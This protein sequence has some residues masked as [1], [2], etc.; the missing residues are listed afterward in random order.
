MRSLTTRLLLNSGDTYLLYSSLASVIEHAKE[1]HY[2][3]LCDTQGAT[4]TSAPNRHP[5]RRPVV[6][7]HCPQQ[8]LK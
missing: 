7:Y 1:G 2:M 5:G 3:V 8:F 6:N 4:R